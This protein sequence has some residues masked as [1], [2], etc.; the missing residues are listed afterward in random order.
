M[1]PPIED[2]ARLLFFF[3]SLFLGH[4]SQMVWKSSKR[5]GIGESGSATGKFYI[6]AS[7]YPPGN[8][9]GGFEENVLPKSKYSQ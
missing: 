3:T 4:F 8:T 5:I 1:H 9:D 6:V 7:Y 2:W